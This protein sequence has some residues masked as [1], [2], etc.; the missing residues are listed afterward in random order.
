MVQTACN[1]CELQ[2]ETEETVEHQPFNTTGR[3]QMAHTP[4]DE[5]NT[6]AGVR[7]YTRVTPDSIE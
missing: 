7:I 3:R 5:I 2:A 4:L 1:H 6:W